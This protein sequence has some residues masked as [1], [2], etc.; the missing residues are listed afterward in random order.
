MQI[1]DA[2]QVRKLL[3]TTAEDRLG[4]LY[5]LAVFTGIREGELFAL[6]WSDIDLGREWGEIDLER[7]RGEP[8]PDSGV[9]HIRRTLRSAIKGFEFGSP[10]TDKSTRTIAISSTVTG[11][12]LEHRTRQSAEVI[13]LGPAWDQSD[14]VFANTVGSHL[15]PQNFLR[16]DFRPALKRAGLPSI[17][18]HQL[19]HTAASLAL[20]QGVPVAD[21]SAML[22]HA[23]PHI[24][25]KIYAHI[26]PGSERQTAAAME[27][28]I[29]G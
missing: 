12:L 18:F 24:T 8:K 13:A 22:G 10:K 9:I 17:T 15:S 26:M 29:N 2:D 1:L 5:A 25:L 4:S 14:L 6:R 21:V 23:G 11:A 27:N 3:S 7:G 19:R 16:R 20:A 28:A